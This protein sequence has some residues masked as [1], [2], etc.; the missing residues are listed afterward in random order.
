MSRS[1]KSILNETQV[2]LSA[3]PESLVFRNNTGQA[4]QGE[5]IYARL[6]SFVKVEPGMV[7]LRRARRIRFGLPGS[8]DLLGVVQRRA[9]AVETKTETGRQAEQQR[10]FGAAW[11]RCG[12]IYV[13]ARSAT[14]AI[15]RLRERIG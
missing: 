10:L 7:I 15:A 4:W 2:E 12:G 14:E 8:A 1:E 13:L 5:E 6:G 3:L 9:V 11:E